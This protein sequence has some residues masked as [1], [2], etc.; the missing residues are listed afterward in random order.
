M[1]LS[2][3]HE[4]LHCICIFNSDGANSTVEIERKNK[5]EIYYIFGA[6]NN[7]SGMNYSD[8]CAFQCTMFQRVKFMSEMDQFIRYPAFGSFMR[9]RA[10]FSSDLLPV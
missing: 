4:Q 5:E 9:P 6:P 2:L 8:N 7:V 1:P 3:R 10:Q